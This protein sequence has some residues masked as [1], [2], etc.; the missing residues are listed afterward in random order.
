[1]VVDLKGQ[2]SEKWAVMAEWLA[3]WRWNSVFKG[4]RLNPS[5]NHLFS[6]GRGSVRDIVSS[7]RVD[8]AL[9]GLDLKGLMPSYYLLFF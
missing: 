9:A 6:L 8:P 7:A 5:C 4:H 1:M 2:Q 3:R